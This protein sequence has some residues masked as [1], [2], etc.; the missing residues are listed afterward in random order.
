MTKKQKKMLIRI[1]L[2]FVLL[3]GLYFITV[4]GWLRFFAY[5]AVYVLIG[6]DVLKKAG[7]GIVNRCPFDE[8]F[9]MAVATVGA[10][11]LAVWTKSGDYTEAIAVMLFYQTGEW[12]QHFAVG[13]SRKSISALMDIRPDYANLEENGAIQKTFEGDQIQPD[14]IREALNHDDND[15]V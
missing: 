12:F 5:F 8:N 15:P 3:I 2:T 14:T 4:E 9:L 11:A 10:F 6:H 1:L 13:K 7:K